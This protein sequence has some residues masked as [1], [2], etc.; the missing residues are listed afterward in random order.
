[1]I[2]KNLVPDFYFIS[3]EKFINQ[4]NGVTPRRWVQQANP[5]LAAFLHQHLAKE[6]PTDLQQ[7]AGLE[8]LADDVGAIDEIRTIKRANKGTLCRLIAERHG[9][10]LD[11]M[12]MF[13]CQV[14]RIHEYK[15][16]LLNILHVIDLYLEIKEGG[17]TIAP[18]VHLFAGKAAPSYAVAKLIIQLIGCVAQRI[19]QDA[20]VGGQLKVVFLEDYK[21]SLAERIIP[22]TDLSE[23]ISTAGTEA[24]GTS[25]MKF[26]LNGALTI[27][28]L[29]GANIEIRDAVG[30][31]NF[32]CSVPPQRKS[33]PSGA[34]VTTVA[35]IIATTRVSPVWWTH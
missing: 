1:M 14:K 27:G 2:K 4:T 3:P 24:S 12:A 16:Q 13:D 30:A 9:I 10:H 6:W 8:K 22:A 5:P 25:N 18:K 32:T 23:Q 29:D 35:I 17:K 21:V 7:L 34:A 33:T 20:R 19:N 26:A 11:P 28:T 15:R 31:D